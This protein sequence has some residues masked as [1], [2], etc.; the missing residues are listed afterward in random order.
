[1]KLL[2]I[3]TVSIFCVLFFSTTINA[4]AVYVNSQQAFDNA[5]DGS[6]DTIIWREG[7]Y[8]DIYMDISNNNIFITAETLGATIF[9]G[10]SRVEITG[11]DITLQG[12]QFLDGDID[13]RDVINIR[14]DRILITQINI[15]GYRSYKYLRVR[16]SSEYVDITYCNFENRLNLDDQNIL[17][18]LV[19]ESNPGYH[20]IQYC[21]FKNFDGSGNDLGIEPIRIGLSTQANRISRTLVEYCYFTQ[22]NGDGEIISS[23]ASQNVYRFNTFEDNPKAELVLRHGSEAIVYGNFF[24][25]GK[26]GVRVREGQNH[27]IYNNYFFGLEDRPIYLQNERSDPLANINIAFNTI[28]ECAEIR[29]GGNGNDQPIEVTFANN[30]FGDPDDSLFEDPTGTET[31]IGNMASGSLGIILPTTGIRNLNPELVEN[32]KGFWGLTENSP[33]INAADSGYKP[34]PQF[35]GIA[36]IDTEILFDLMGQHRPSEIAQKDLGCNEY[37]HNI[38]IQPIATEENTGPIYNMPMITSVQNNT[39]IVE[40]LIEVNPNPVTNQL[41]LTIHSSRNIDIQVAIFNAEGSK[42]RTIATQ[43]NFLGEM[44]L[45]KNIADLPAG[46]YTLRAIGSDYQESVK[47][48]QTIKFVKVI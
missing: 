26:G 15:Q 37:P 2:Q 21:S 1:M 29:L 19:H 6:A 24:L 39:L 8:S 16:E 47:R 20:K 4:E 28:V 34:L 9:N 45:S 23:K 32:S 40:D 36:E 44:M 11:D 7:T 41:H 14:G 13:T 5:H 17:S 30:I 48:V 46:L 43:T 3:I 42:I 38:L 35:D 12:F 33:A 25:N 22:C 31:W 27:Y 10:A 18:I